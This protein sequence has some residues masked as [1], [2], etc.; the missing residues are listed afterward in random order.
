SQFHDAHAYISYIVRYCTQVLWRR[1]SRRLARSSAAA[2]GQ[3]LQVRVGRAA[4][5]PASAADGHLRRVGAPLRAIAVGREE[6][7]PED[8]APGLGHTQ[9]EPRLDERG[10]LARGGGGAHQ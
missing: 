9:V 4:E 2:T 5:H 7:A 8:E 6:G 1:Q 3:L 10:L